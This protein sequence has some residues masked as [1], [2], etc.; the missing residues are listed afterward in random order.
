MA[1]TDYIYQQETVLKKDFEAWLIAKMQAAGWQ[2]IGSNPPATPNDSTNSRFYVMK[3]NRASDNMDTYV[4][5]NGAGIRAR[6]NI[7]YSSQ[8]NLVPLLDYTPGAAGS[9]GTTSKGTY[10]L[11]AAMQSPSSN[12]YQW[13]LF[14]TFN[15]AIYPADTPLNVRFCITAH[16]VSIVVRTPNYYAEGGGY[17][18]FGLPDILGKEKNSGITTVTGS[19]SGSSSNSYFLVAD[20]PLNIPSTVPVS[21]VTAYEVLSSYSIAP[22]KSPDVNGLFML[23]IAYGGDGTS[24][25]RLRHPTAFFLP[26]GGL[27]DGDLIQ[28]QGMTFEILRPQYPMTGGFRAGYVVYRIA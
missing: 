6:N 28:Y 17:V 24:G 22:S 8:M 7:A 25:M 4:A 27:L 11:A 1:A 20:T 5:I 14:G 2:Q 21:A 13:T 10:P 9:S 19:C 12:A 16:N 26:D 15:T 18:F 23:V 3:G